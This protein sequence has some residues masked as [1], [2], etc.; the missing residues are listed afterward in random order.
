MISLL[1]WITKQSAKVNKKPNICKIIVM[2]VS[3]LR[4]KWKITMQGYFYLMLV[5]SNTNKTNRF[6]R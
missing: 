2:V 1:I 5:A 6:L 3:V 4:G